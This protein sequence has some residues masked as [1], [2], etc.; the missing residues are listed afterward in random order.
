M[1]LLGVSLPPDTLD[2]FATWRAGGLRARLGLRSFKRSVGVHDSSEFQAH[3]S[4]VRPDGVC[5]MRSSRKLKWRSAAQITRFGHLNTKLYDT[6]SL[7]LRGFSKELFKR[8]CYLRIV[9][10]TCIVLATTESH[11]LLLNRKTG[12]K[13][14][15]GKP[16]FLCW[17][18]ACTT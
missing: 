9:L 10:A 15:F 14:R 2:A 16:F 18:D 6:C 1:D 17:L 11:R 8:Y 7:L 12:R 13:S 4:T 3:K 5:L